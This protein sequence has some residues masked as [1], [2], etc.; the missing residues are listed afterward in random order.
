VTVGRTSQARIVH[1]LNYTGVRRNTIADPIRVDGGTLHVPG[2]VSSA[3]S[4]RLGTAL[5]VVQHG[6]HATVTLPAIGLFDVLELR[7]DE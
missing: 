5:S 4:R 7:D 2:R 3:R 1:L 6:E